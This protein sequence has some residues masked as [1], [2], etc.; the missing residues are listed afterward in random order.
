MKKAFGFAMAA[1]M[2]IDGAASADILY[3][4]PPV[5]PRALKIRSILTSQ[6][7]QRTWLLTS[8]SLTPGS[9]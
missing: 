5:T 4:N 8:I 2:V 7:T 1:A 6:P 9:H 3:H